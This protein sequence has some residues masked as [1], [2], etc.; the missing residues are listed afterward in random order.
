MQRTSARKAL[1]EFAFV[2]RL[3]ALEERAL[4]RLV[5]AAWAHNI[6]NGVTGV[7]R[8]DGRSLRQIIEGETETILPL[9]ARILADPRHGRVAVTAFGEIG[10]R[11][12]GSWHVEGLDRAPLSPALTRRRGLLVDAGQPDLRVPVRTA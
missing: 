10:H 8:L 3:A 2:S 5:G 7:M 9:A 6:R 1:V 12:F 4:A 11:R